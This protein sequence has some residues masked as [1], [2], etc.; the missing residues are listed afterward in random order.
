MTLMNRQSD[1]ALE[2]DVVLRLKVAINQ[3]SLELWN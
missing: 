1:N 3:F 2:T